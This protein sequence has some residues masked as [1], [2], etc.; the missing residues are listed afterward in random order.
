MFIS[1]AFAQTANAT[2][3]GGGFASLVQF[4]PLVLIVIV[5]YFLLI[6]PQQK[7]QKTLRTKLAG[8]KRGDRVVTAGGIVGTVKKSTDASAD[9]DVE[10]APNVTV[11]VVRSTITTVLGSGTDKAS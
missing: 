2:A 7:Q 5:F 11:S 6:R 3:S 4:A 1:P 9:I 10:I 8:L